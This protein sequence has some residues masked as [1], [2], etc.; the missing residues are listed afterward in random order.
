[1]FSVDDFSSISIA[2]LVE[3]GDWQRQYRVITQWGRMVSP[4]PEIRV[5]DNLIKGCELPVWLAHQLIDGKHYF[6]VD[7][8]SRVINGLA[9]L[10]LVQLTGKTTHELEGIVLEEKLLSSGLEKHLTPSRNNGFR[11]IVKRCNELINISD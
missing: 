4:K 1:V 5:P 6:S 3:A 7:S 11:S 10:L 2:D 8:D 9:V